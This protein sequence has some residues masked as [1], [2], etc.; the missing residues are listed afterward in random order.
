MLDVSRLP[1][2]NTETACSVPY[3]EYMRP[4]GDWQRVKPHPSSAKFTRVAPYQMR[5]N[6][7][8]RE[9]Q[10]SKSLSHFSTEL[11]VLRWIWKHECSHPARWESCGR[12]FRL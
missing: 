9:K 6:K 7:R 12:P 2:P 11:L 1:A 4:T 8:A 3:I 10:Q 5:T